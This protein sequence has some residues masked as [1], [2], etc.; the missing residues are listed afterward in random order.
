MKKL[1]NWSEDDGWIDAW[2]DGYTERPHSAWSV[3]GI[4][5]IF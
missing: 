1:N 4:E 2:M 5:M 3:V